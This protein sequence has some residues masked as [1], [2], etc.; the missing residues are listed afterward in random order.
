[1]KKHLLFVV[2]SMFAFTSTAQ[3]LSSGD[4]TATIS[5]LKTRSYTN[6]FFGR[7]DKV[8]EY[9]GDCTI[10]KKGAKIERYTFSTM[11]IGDD[12][13]TLNVEIPDRGG[14]SLTYDF[15]SKKFEIAG[16]EYKVKSSKNIEDIF[17]SGILIFAKW[18]DEY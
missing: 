12:N 7:N 6:T 10:Q 16:D 5:N 8:I 4:Y 2:L 15:E 9:I 1:M 18:S 17:L 3:Q 13:L 11:L 14:N